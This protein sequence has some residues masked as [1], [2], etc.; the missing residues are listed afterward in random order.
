VPQFRKIDQV[1][2]FFSFQAGVVEAA[3]VRPEAA[4]DAVA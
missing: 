4:A 3:G 1:V 2:Q